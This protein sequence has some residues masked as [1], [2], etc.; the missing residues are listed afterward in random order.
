MQTAMSPSASASCFKPFK[1]KKVYFI[2]V[3]KKMYEAVLLKKTLHDPENKLIK[4]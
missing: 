4:S 3:E 2:E 1:S